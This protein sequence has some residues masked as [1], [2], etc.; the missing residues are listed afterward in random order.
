MTTSSAEH[1]FTL[2][3]E[4][5][6]N[7]GAQVPVVYGNSSWDMPDG[8]RLRRE[9]RRSTRMEDVKHVRRWAKRFSDITEQQIADAVAHLEQK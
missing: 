7:L 9:M 6:Y 8:N 4:H 2:K 3:M 5:D 1:W